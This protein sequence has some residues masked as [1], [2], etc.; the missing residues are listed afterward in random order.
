MP[1][2]VFKIAFVFGML[3]L[4]PLY[5]LEQRIGVDEP[6]AIT[7]PEYFYGFVGVALAWQLGFAVIASDPVRYRPIMLPAMFEKLSFGGAAV[8]LYAMGRLSP[9]M[10]GAGLI[11]LVFLG[12]FIAA[13][14]ATPKD[15][16]TRVG[17]L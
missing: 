4:V 11:D 17:P 14:R 10:L 13:Y 12:L 16:P 6:P 2:L 8:I 1:R 15:G 7:H 9:T 5:F 3:A